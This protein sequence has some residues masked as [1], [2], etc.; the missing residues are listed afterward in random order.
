[1]SKTIT[2]EVDDNIYDTIRRAADGDRRTMSKFIEH[3]AVNYIFAS[4]VVD[5]EEMDEIMSFEEDLDVGLEDI[6][7]GKY[8]VVG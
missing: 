5:D 7:A 8:R 6:N 1:M 2:L 4:N 3:A